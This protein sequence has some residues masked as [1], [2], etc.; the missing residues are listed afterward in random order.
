MAAEDRRHGILPERFGIETTRQDG[1]WAVAVRGEVDL[2]TV[3]KLDAA[4]IRLSGPVVL[5]L[6]KVSFIDSM[7]LTSLLRATRNGCTIGKASPAVSRLF[8][9]TGFEEELLHKPR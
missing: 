2:A 6:S 3:D 8:R 5:D 7:G 9:M 4:L 1:H